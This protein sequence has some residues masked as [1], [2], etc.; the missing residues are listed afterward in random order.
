MGGYGSGGHWR[1]HSRETVEDCR[2]LD[3]RR[4]RRDGLLRPGNWFNWQWSRDGV[5]VANIDV[6]VE[7]GRVTLTY[8]FRRREEE[9][10]SIVEPIPIESTPGTYG[11]LRFWFLCPAVGCGQRVALLY[12]SDRYFA[13][14]HCYRLAYPSTR[15]NRGD[16]A[17][18]RA[19]RIRSRL[20]WEPGILNGEGLKPKWMRRK[21]F[22]RLS[23]THYQLVSYALRVMAERLGIQPW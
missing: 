6:R 15:E 1:H 16:R 19:D 11:G 3:V 18:R 23:T 4:W 9:W 17:V 14:R 7:E 21:T 13:C 22:R 8:R 10:E 2:F 20:G 12:G 5:A